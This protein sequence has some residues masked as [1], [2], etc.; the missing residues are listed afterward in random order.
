MSTPEAK[1]VSMTYTTSEIVF[2]ASLG[3]VFG[4]ANVGLGSSVQVAAALLGPLGAAILGGYVQI[5][6]VLGGYIVRRPGAATFTMLV[7]GAV[8]FLAGNPAGAILFLFGLVQGLGA[9]ASYA[10][11][12]YRNYSLPWVLL[13]GG[14]AQVFSHFLAVVLFGWDASSTIFIASVPVT[15]ISGV[16]LAGGIAWLLAKALE[17]SG[18]IK[19]ISRHSW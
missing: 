11:G 18:F 7:N 16:V 3:I 1:K 14:L 6:Q 4:V 5:S 13:A 10:L 15:F 9:E 17:R 2:L 8:Q 19:N 12:R